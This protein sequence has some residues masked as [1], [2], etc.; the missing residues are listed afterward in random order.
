MGM[1]VS[2]QD[3]GQALEGYL[4]GSASARD[5][6]GVLVVPSW[7]N[8]VESTCRR[9]DRLAEIGH[10]TFVADIFG[11]GIRPRPPQ[12]PQEV[13]APFLKDRSQF[14]QRL[15]ASLKAFQQRPECDAD[16]TAAIGLARGGGLW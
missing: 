7:L 11:A 8:V 1:W 10:A 13:V 2:Y 15:L 14:R 4:A 5:L 3:E 12:L 6:P 9:A 16:R